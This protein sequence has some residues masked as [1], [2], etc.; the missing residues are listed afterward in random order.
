M[1]AHVPPSSLAKRTTLRV[2]SMLFRV[3]GVVVDRHVVDGRKVEH[4]V[5]GAVKLVVSSP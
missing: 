1:E 4:V 5:D 2:P 3:S